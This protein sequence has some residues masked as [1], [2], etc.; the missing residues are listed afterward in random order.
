LITVSERVS[1]TREA[2]SASH[3]YSGLVK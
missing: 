3:S 1:S 2:T